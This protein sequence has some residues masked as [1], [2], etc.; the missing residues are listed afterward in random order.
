MIVSFCLST[1]EVHVECWYQCAYSLVRIE[2]KRHIRSVKPLK[3]RCGKLWS[4]QHF[5]VVAALIFNAGKVL[6]VQRGDSKYLYTAYKYEFPGG[7]IEPQETPEAALVREIEEELAMAI[8]VGEAYLTVHHA[9]PDFAVTLHSFVCQAES[10]ALVLKEHKTAQ[11]RDPKDLADLH[12]AAADV[13]I[14]EKLAQ[15]TPR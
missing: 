1:Y 7:K 5:E 11:W 2:R 10:R 12:W 13:P 6:C 9:Y 3:R 15:D 4:M 8:T 14:V